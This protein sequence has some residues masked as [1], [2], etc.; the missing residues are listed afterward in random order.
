MDVMIAQSMA[1]TQDF[2]TKRNAGCISEERKS[3]VQSMLMQ[4]R[5]Y[6]MNNSS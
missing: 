4:G 1:C 2:L 6:F 3:C 5:G